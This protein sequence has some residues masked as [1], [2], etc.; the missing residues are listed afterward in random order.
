MRCGSKHGGSGLR[1]TQPPSVQRV[2]GVLDAAAARALS[3]PR[4]R[5]GRDATGRAGE[6]VLFGKPN[7]S[8]GGSSTST[9]PFRRVA[10]SR[11][12]GVR[13]ASLQSP[14]LGR[15]LQ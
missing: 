4:T 2:Q 15:T 3:V 7:R 13:I 6:F 8:C 9:L 12:F 11:V 14:R 1:G 5:F 10:G